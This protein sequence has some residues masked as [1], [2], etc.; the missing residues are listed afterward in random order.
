MASSLKYLYWD[1]NTFLAYMNEEKDRVQ[2]LESLL[3]ECSNK[4]ERKILTSV[5]AKIEVAFVN[6]ERES[7]KLNPE[8][9]K[10]IDALWEDT[11]AIEIVEV[12]EDIAHR[13]RGLMRFAASQK[14]RLTAYDATH[15]ATAAWARKFFDIEEFHTYDGKLFKFSQHIGIKIC[16]PFIAQQRL[17]I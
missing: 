12:N 14:V 5:M 6:S 3:A 8:I 4:G 11:S 7:G 9:E 17:D 16:Y 15:L 10:A 2:T 1:S 13:A